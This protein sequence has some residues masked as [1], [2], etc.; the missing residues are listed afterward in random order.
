METEK[1][2]FFF[3]K[4]WHKNHWTPRFSRNPR[5]PSYLKAFVLGRGVLA[6]AQMPVWLLDPASCSFL[7]CTWACGWLQKWLLAPVSELLSSKA[8]PLFAS[9]SVAGSREARGACQ[10]CRACWHVTGSH[11]L[12]PHKCFLTPSS[13]RSEKMNVP[14]LHPEILYPFWRCPSVLMD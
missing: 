2:K 14:H 1:Q 10:L 7:F 11:N 6:W 12:D 8:L 5:F 3:F 4:F 9:N 13:E